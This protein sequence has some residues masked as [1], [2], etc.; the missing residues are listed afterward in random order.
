MN[1]FKL[2]L[3][4]VSFVALS[5]AAQAQTLPENALSTAEP[6]RVSEQFRDMPVAPSVSPEI[7]VKEGDAQKAPPGAENITLNLKGL[8]IGGVTAYNE[9]EI[10]HIYAPYIGQNISLAQVYSI[11]NQL[12][13]KYRNDGYMLAQVVIP[14]QTIDNGIV[15]LQVVE[16]VVDS[17]VV[18]GEETAATDLIRRYASQIA[19]GGPLNS[20]QL[21]RQLLLINDLPG[22]TARSV[23]S[24]STNVVGA[25]DLRII[26]ERDPFD[27]LIGVNNNGSK[28]LGPLQFVGAATA[29]N[30]FHLNESIT[31]QVV[32]APQSINPFDNELGYIALQYD[33]PV[34]SYGTMLE[35]FVSHTDTEPGFDL[36]QFDVEGKSTFAS[37]G[38]EHPFI[39]SRAQNLY[40]RVSFDYRNVKTSNNLPEPTREDDIR[41]LRAG[42][43][44]DFLDT[45]LGV[46]INSIDVELSKGLDIFGA[47]DEGEPNLSRAFG[48][49]DFT[50]LNA[51]VQRLQRITSSVNLLLVGSA[52]WSSDALLA[53][54]EFGVGGIGIGRAFDPSE[55]VGDEGIAGKVEVQ[56][57]QPVQW[58]LVEDYQVFGFYDA[59]RVW[60]DD[61][62]TAA[63]KKDTATSTGFGIR[64]EFAEDVNADLTV[65]IPLNRDVETQRD[66]DPRVYFSLTKQF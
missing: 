7:S 38:L 46:G 3:F 27:A 28:Y 58:N 52:Q 37:I 61:P 13:L 17:V 19:T 50:K 53:S 9:A 30:F 2:A 33:M 18:Q 31:G 62:T 20:S 44:Y 40:G 16:G 65:A 29:N 43:R 49:P 54:E 47:S 15:N 64:T 22:V 60:N 48:D 34:W 63:Q 41:A 42:V 26:V 10:S 24:P 32:F 11:A 56:W 59:G 1:K 35:I 8:N 39:R 21:E 66:R 14:P 45:L 5:T 4:S 55:I 25:A 6:G 12:K 23:L 57:N 36:E 51:E